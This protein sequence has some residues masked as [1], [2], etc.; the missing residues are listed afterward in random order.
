MLIDDM[1]PYGRNARKNEAAIPKVAE[2][3]RE[4]GLRGTIGLE[5]RENPVIVFGHTRVAAC[6][7]LGW[8]EIPDERVEFCD[9]LTPEQVKAFRIADNKTG[10]IATYNKAMLREEVRSLKDFDMS[11]FGLDFKSRKL[12]YGAER[13]KTDRAY[14]LDLVS[15]VDC[16]PGGFPLLPRV[17]ARPDGLQGFN[18]AKSTPASGKAGMG[19]HFF[20]DDYQFERVWT[21]PRRYIE[22]LRPYACV[23]TPDFSLYLDM[24]APMQAW[25]RYRSQ[26][27]GRYWAGEGLT[28]VPTLSWAQPDSYAFCFEGIA[29]RS[30]VAVS[31]V[32]VK[33]DRA[34]SGVW[35]DGMREAMRALEPSRVLL[36]GGRIEFDFG[37]CEVVDYG[38]GGFHG[39]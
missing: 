36:Y 6:R 12:S 39:R 24:P 20:I 3:I 7:S 22:A 13:F 33:G 38:G 4:F 10:D 16:G 30:T 18:Y 17:D 37:G 32:G 34:A 14:N 11:R 28:V 19:C 27:L 15:R 35:A 23:L 8:T 26:A 21:S 25:N 9:D 5:S 29:R 31:T 1:I 2:S